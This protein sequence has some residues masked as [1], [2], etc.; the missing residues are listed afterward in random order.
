MKLPDKD[1]AKLVTHLRDV[2]GEAGRM[3]DPDHPP[4][5]TTLER[6]VG[7]FRYMPDIAWSDHY[8]SDDGVFH[9]RDVGDRSDHLAIHDMT[10]TPEEDGERYVLRIS[11]FLLPEAQETEEETDDLEETRPF[12]LFRGYCF[13]LSVTKTPLCWRFEAPVTASL[14]LNIVNTPQPIYREMPS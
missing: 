3:I 11:G 8:K 5:W 1:A 2:L 7:S 13:G 10:A 12:F 6:K 14:L 9:F 4:G